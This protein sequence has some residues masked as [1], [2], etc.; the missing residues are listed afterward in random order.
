[1]AR[2]KPKRPKAPKRSASLESWKNY[3]KRLSDWKAK[4]R[5]IESDKKSKS[6]I[7][8]RLSRVA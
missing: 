3:G 5:K 2:R 7:I 6:T 4:C 1:M 8:S